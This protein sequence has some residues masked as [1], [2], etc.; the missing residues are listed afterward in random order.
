MTG[1]FEGVLESLRNQTSA[2][3]EGIDVAGR[4]SIPS[5]VRVEKFGLVVVSVWILV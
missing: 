4:F 5:S 2:S 1:P 3:V